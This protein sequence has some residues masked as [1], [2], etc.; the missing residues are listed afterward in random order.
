VA[1][2]GYGL[3]GAYLQG[4]LS[5]VGTLSQFVKLMPSETPLVSMNRFTALGLV[6]KKLLGDNAFICCLAKKDR[7]RLSLSPSTGRSEGNAVPGYGL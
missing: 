5:E 2:R 4:Y 3:Y 1:R 7:S 6:Q